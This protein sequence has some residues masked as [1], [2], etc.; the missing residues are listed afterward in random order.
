ML[1]VLF[2]HTLK[3]STAVHNDEK[4]IVMMKLKKTGK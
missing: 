2:N 1:V 4:V 3:L